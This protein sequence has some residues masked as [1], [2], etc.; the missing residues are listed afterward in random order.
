MFAI[1]IFPHG[2]NF[3]YESLPPSPPPGIFA[4]F[5]KTLHKSYTSDTTMETSRYLDVDKVGN[6]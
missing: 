3:T 1:S 6:I 5:A 2:C 4:N